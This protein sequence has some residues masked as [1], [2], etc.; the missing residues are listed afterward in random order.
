M[1]VSDPCDR[2]VSLRFG[3]PP[4]KVV[5]TDLMENEIGGAELLGSGIQGFRRLRFSIG[6]LRDQNV[7]SV[8]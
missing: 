8:V 2:A 7:Q 4:R 6:L 5:E 1:K 3:L